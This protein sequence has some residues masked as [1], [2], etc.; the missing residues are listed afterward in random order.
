MLGPLRLSDLC[1][2]YSRYKVKWKILERKKT[3]L[4]CCLFIH[5]NSIIYCI[6][7]LYSVKL[8]EAGGG[9]TLTHHQLHMGVHVGWRDM[10][11]DPQNISNI[12]QK[13]ASK[14]DGQ[15]LDAQEVHNSTSFLHPDTLKTIFSIKPTVE[16]WCINTCMYIVCLKPFQQYFPWLQSV[17]Q[18]RRLAPELS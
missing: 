7:S 9:G 11:P 3:I 6:T 14:D 8:R 16:N 5:T 4:H 13:H 18:N 12:T 1:N 17:S 2:L 15:V 10:M